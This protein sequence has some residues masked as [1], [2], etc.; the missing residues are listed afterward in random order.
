MTG[1]APATTTASPKQTLDLELHGGRS[2]KE[3]LLV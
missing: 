3:L 1:T 2:I